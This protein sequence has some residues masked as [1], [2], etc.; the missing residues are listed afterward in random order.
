MRL[1]AGWWLVILGLFDW[2][3]FGFCGRAYLS[4]VISAGCSTGTAVFCGFVFILWFYA[5]CSLGGSLVCDL[6][7]RCDV[8]W[9]L[10]CCLG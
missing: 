1:I 7:L 2:W 4:F 5:F 3:L 6:L 8:W 10:I 9:R